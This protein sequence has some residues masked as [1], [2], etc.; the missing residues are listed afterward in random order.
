MLDHGEA[1]D[2]IIAVLSND[3]LWSDVADVSELPA[4]YVDRLIHYFGTYKN[5][6]G[7]ETVVE[8]GEVYGREFAESVVKASIADYD[9][10]FGG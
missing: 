5:L 2:K 9:A 1:D 6:P 4:A 10:E 3:N 7:E 8:V